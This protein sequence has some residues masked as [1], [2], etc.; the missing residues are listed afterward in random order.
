MDESAYKQRV[1]AVSLHQTILLSGERVQQPGQAQ[2]AD[3]ERSR[4][5]NFKGSCALP[6]YGRR[7]GQVEH[8]VSCAGC[9]LAIEK[10][11]IGARA[12]EWAWEARDK[13]YSQAGFLEH[14]RWCEQAQLLWKMSEAGTR[15]PG[16]LP[17]VA[18]RGGLFN[19]RE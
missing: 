4:K 2:P 13:V 11:I 3:S 6:Y 16:A 18:R 14:F 1:T 8:G 5:Y 9:Q 19:L 17:E 15:R 10:R 7:T 12:E